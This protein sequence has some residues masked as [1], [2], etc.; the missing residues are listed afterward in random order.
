MILT[1][2][3]VDAKTTELYYNTIMNDIIITPR[4]LQRIC[5]SDRY[6]VLDDSVN[7]ADVYYEDN[8]TAILRLSC[9][10]GT[11]A[12]FILS[13]DTEISVYSCEI[14]ISNVM[15]YFRSNP[16]PTPFATDIVLTVYQPVEDIAVPL[17]VD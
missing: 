9:A 17:I 15:Q 10:G 6:M 16:A 14:T 4:Q 5:A 7:Q 1:N 13:E 8:G 2:G 11:D 12:E 3:V